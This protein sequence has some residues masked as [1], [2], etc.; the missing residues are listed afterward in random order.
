MLSLKEF[1]QEVVQQLQMRLKDASPAYIM[2]LNPVAKNNNQ[3]LTVLT[4]RRADSLIGVN[5]YLNSYYEDYLEGR[6]MQSVLEELETVHDLHIQQAPVD[7]HRAYEYEWAKDRI[8]CRLSAKRH[9]DRYLADK[10]Y[11]VVEDLA[12]TYHVLVGEPEDAVVST[13]VTNALMDHY[14]VDINTIHRLAVE[15][16]KRLFPP[17]V[18]SLYDTISQ[19]VPGMETQPAPEDAPTIL[20]ITNRAKTYGASAILDTDTMR[21][22]GRQLGGEFYVLPSS[23][24]EVLAV[25]KGPGMDYHT[26]EM[27]VQEVNETQV[28]PQEVLSGHVYE[29][30]PKECRLHRCRPVN[31]ELE[32]EQKKPDVKGPKL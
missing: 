29:V 31:P 22:V 28:E 7:A 10:P 30:D 17:T 21:E 8:I 11:T 1:S 6:D 32:H 9:K 5:V 3:M 15:N 12:V 25:K 26:L 19:M 13:P 24:H 27:M 16:T 2:Q 23:V 20:I 14:G 4:I 18:M